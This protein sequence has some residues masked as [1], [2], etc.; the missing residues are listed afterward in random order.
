MGEC[1]CEADTDG[2]SVEPGRVLVLL[3]LPPSEFSMP[4]HKWKT[5]LLSRPYSVAKGLIF[6]SEFV[7]L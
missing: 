6:L 3:F 1:L 2:C 4:L 5:S 7:I